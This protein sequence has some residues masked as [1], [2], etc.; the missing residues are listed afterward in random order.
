LPS[1][2]SASCSPSDLPFVS[3]D[4]AAD[5]ALRAAEP[6][7]DVFFDAKGEDEPEKPPNPADENGLALALGPPNADV[8]DPDAVEDLA[9]GE[10]DDENAPNVACGFLA[11]NG[12]ADGVSEG[13]IVFGVAVLSAGG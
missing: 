7:A 11:G 8:P 12:P 4:P 9:K 10:A 1:P 6:N 13:G 2:P 5:V 3:D